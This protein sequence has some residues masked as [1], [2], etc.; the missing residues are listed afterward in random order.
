MDE[1]GEEEEWDALL[2]L[3]CLEWVSVQRLIVSR[4]QFGVSLPVTETS[5]G[6][7]VK[8]LELFST[9]VYTAATRRKV[10]T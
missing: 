6:G 8:I 2:S 3:K 7:Q 9:E 4:L 5:F 1:Y 10:T